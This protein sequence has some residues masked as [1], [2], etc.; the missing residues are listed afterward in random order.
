MKIQVLTMFALI[1]LT[2][3]NSMN[4]IEVAQQPSITDYQLGEKWIWKYKGVTS[5]G[6]VRAQGK[7]I[8]QIIE[9]NGQ[10]AMLTANGPVALEQIIKPVDN[11]NARYNW[12]LQVGK[13]WQ[14]AENW[15]SEDGTTSNSRGYKVQSEDVHWYAPKL[16]TFI[17]LTQTQGDYLYV[18]ELV[19]YS[20]H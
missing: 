14:L 18:E 11:K 12:P 16:K 8:K 10:L 2:G 1:V 17:K 9:Q 5:D 7:D 4:D 19:E 15:T 20:E 13:K 6:T 3:C